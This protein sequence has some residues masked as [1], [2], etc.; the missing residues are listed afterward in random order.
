MKTRREAL[1]TFSFLA[2]STVLPAH[3]AMAGPDTVEVHTSLLV[4]IMRSRHGGRWTV[5]QDEKNEFIL[6]HKQP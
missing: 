5:T 6:I 4:D 3:L 2:A 1:S